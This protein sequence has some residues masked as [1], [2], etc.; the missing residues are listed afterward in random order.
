MHSALYSSQQYCYVSSDGY[1]VDICILY[2]ST[3]EQLSGYAHTQL[4]CGS[5]E[6]LDLVLLT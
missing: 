2:W 4:N 5:L 6:Q 1:T 3:D